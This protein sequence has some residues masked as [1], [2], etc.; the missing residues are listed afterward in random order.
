MECLKEVQE[1]NIFL[2]L[3][4][5]SISNLIHEDKKWDQFKKIY[6]CYENNSDILFIYNIISK[7]KHRFSNLLIFNINFDNFKK[8]IDK[9]LSLYVDKIV[10]HDL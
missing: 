1:I 9:K 7:L 5:N 2:S 6:S 4:N 10:M 3:L 8:H